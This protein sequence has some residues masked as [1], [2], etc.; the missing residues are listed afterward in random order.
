MK[1]R[2]VWLSIVA[3]FLVRIAPTHALDRTV[4]VLDLTARNGETGDKDIFSLNQAL[5]VAGVP[6]KVTNDL[7]TATRSGM[8]VTTSYI[9][10]DTFETESDR[11]ALRDYVNNGGILVATNVSDTSLA[12]LFGITKGTRTDTRYTMSWQTGTGD[13]GL[14]YFDDPNEQTVRFGNHRYLNVIPTRSFGLAGGVALAK[15]D[16]GSNG[17]VKNAY[18]LGQTYVLGFSFSDVILRSELNL[19]YQAQIT[20]SNGFEPTTDTFFLFLRAIYEDRMPAPVWKHTSPGSTG[21][22]VVL[23]HDVDAQSSI[24]FMNTFAEAERQRGLSATYFITTRYIDDAQDTDYFDAGVDPVKDLLLKNRKLGSH[25]V[26]HFP[27]FQ[28][29]TRFPEGAP[30]NTRENYH[31][32]CNGQLVT[33]GGNVYGELEVSKHLL[34]TVVG[35]PAI[36]C[37]RSGYLLFNKKLINVLDALGYKYDS[38]FNANA[39]LTNFPC[40]SRY[41]QSFSGAVSDVYEIPI[42]ISDSDLYETRLKMTA[43]NYSLFVDCWIDVVRRNLGNFAMTVLLIHPTYDYKLR[44]QELFLD[45]LPVNL[46]VTDMETFGAYWRE[47][48]RFAFLSEVSDDTLAI[49]VLSTT[50]F[51][52]HPD[53]S[54]YVRDGAGLEHIVAGTADGAPVAFRTANGALP[55]DRILDMFRL[56]G[57]VT[58][59]GRVDILDVIACLRMATELDTPDPALADLNSD[60]TVDIQD[61][62]L[63]L[64]GCLR[65]PPSAKAGERSGGQAADRTGELPS[66]RCDFRPFRQCMVPVLLLCDTMSRMVE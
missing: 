42:T 37:F 49:T 58:L 4:A 11:T 41:D 64:K 25:S 14:K 55:A 13:P 60:G 48:E 9:A 31:P 6:F 62:V 28:D 40:L 33:T 18:G 50:A 17:V 7:P 59:D 26:G 54:L 65:G 3:L 29:E 51:P 23:S 24:G 30:G 32:Y 66:S 22:T 53:V 44:A 43:D 10:G 39:L 19:D 45:Q 38:S 35:A 34:E 27:D 57:D 1:N 16:D 12:E 8:I 46:R 63:V 20:T 5:S 21:S 2:C 52:V 47:R 15:Y 56:L 36:S 61:V